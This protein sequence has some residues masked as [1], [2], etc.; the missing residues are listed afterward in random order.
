MNLCDP[1][2]TYWRGSCGAAR[3]KSKTARKK[4]SALKCMFKCQTSCE[5]FPM[6]KKKLYEE[7]KVAHKSCF[8]WLLKISKARDAAGVHDGVCAANWE[9]EVTAKLMTGVCRWEGWCRPVEEGDSPSCCG[10]M[11]LTSV[12]LFFFLALELKTDCQ[13]GLKQ[14]P[15]SLLSPHRQC[16]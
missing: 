7:T 15:L 3:S 1:W 8:N 11:K 14:N 6:K 16:A 2:I 4:T 5:S 13:T 9:E 10:G 12:W